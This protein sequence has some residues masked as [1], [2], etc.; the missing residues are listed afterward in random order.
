VQT[1]LFD[2]AQALQQALALHRQGQL[3]DAEK[4]YT[5]VLKAAPGNFDALHLLA[6]VK[7]DAKQMG[8]AYR[9]MSAALKINPNIPD[10][11][12]NYANVLHALKRDE[13]ALGALDK[14]L[15]LRPDDPGLT[16]QRGNALLT[17]GRPSDAL[18]CFDAALKANPGNS[19]ALNGR[20]LALATLGQTNEA[21]AAFDAA[22]ATAPLR[23]DIL[24]NRGN[25]LLALDRLNE[26][27]TAFDRV[28]ARVPG[29]NKAWINR[30]RALQSLNRPAEAVPCF[31][32]AVALD[33]D[34]ADAHFNLAL[35]LLSIGEYERGFREYE[36]RW[37]RT[38]M[39]ARKSSKPLWLGE[40]PPGG[41]TI[42]LQAEQG[43]GDTIQ[44]ARY[45]PLLTKLG[46][47]VALEVHPELKATMAGI[48]GL[49]SCHARGEPLPAFDRT[50]P[51]GSLPL[52]LKT[53]PATIPAQIPYLTADQSRLAQWSERLGPA[54]G[55]RVAIAWAGQA[56]HVNDRNRSLDL[57]LLAPLFGLPG[58][59]FVSIQRD[60]RDG[61]AEKLARMPGLTHVGGELNDMAD[62]AAVQ[63][64][65]D[66][67]LAV[68]TSVVHLAGALGRPVWIMLPLA[69]DW[70]WGVSAETSAWYPQ[71]RLFR[72][73][74]VGDWANVI[75][76]VRDALAQFAAT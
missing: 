49:M 55:K 52:A 23:P 50:C 5:R 54:S 66:L 53:T 68:D 3:R 38:G 15:A 57:D 22:L 28:L 73:T 45:I 2:P 21:L 26:A 48:A 13:E 33:R 65:C 70:R 25:A 1:R 29:H 30:G 11:W 37:K 27:V 7:V 35:A 58:L 44:F 41:R 16:Q 71:A 60:L 74:A 56:R 42:L 51:M 62:T 61:D 12:A 76:R 6:L 67:T 24:Y 36:W 18:A 34:D 4:I 63:A 47:K 32:K 72:Q 20:G 75:A 59:D 19:D 10:I 9:L 39:P 31:E 43:L 14:A 69:A 46:A 64:L 17:L 8:E 40:F